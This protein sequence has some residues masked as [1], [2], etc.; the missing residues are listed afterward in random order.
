MSVEGKSGITTEALKTI[1]EKINE[2]TSKGQILYF[3]L[4][5]DDMSI[6]EFIEIE[7]DILWVC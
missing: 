1:K 3:S 5:I 7:N 2:V 6:R 4:T